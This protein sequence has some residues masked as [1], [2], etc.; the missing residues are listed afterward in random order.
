MCQVLAIVL[1]QFRTL[2]LT[3]YFA[4]LTLQIYFRTEQ[5]RDMNALVAAYVNKMMAH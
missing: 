4:V 2:V 1:R 5:G 3:I